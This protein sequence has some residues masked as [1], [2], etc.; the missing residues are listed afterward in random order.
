MTEQELAEHRS[1]LVRTLS[2]TLQSA[3]ADRLAQAFMAV[4]RHRYLP[5]LIGVEGDVRAG[6]DLAVTRMS[7]WQAASIYSDDALSLRPGDPCLRSTSSAPGI[8]WRMIDMLCLDPGARVLE[9]GCGSGYN[10]AVMGH[11]VGP[12]GRVTS[13]E[14]IADVAHDARV[15]LELEGVTNVDV[16]VGDGTQGREAGAPYDAVMV[17]AAARDIF[18]AWLWQLREGGRLVTVLETGLG[19]RL[20]GMARRGETLDGAFGLWVAFVPV[21]GR[22]ATYPRL[23]AAAHDVSARWERIRQVNS[24]TVP[25]ASSLTG[26]ATAGRGGLLSF[27]ELRLGLRAVC[28]SGSGLRADLL[29][30]SADGESFAAVQTS[31][32]AEAHSVEVCGSTSIEEELREHSSAFV[33]AGCPT[34]ENGRVVARRIGSAQRVGTDVLGEREYFEYGVC[35]KGN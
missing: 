4:P 15:C 28:S 33:K 25:L 7:P 13:V 22:E 14:V 35:G 31:W 1:R 2:A 20:L 23:S 21:V 18:P 16:L 24:R 29:M 9:I 17:T 34:V 10:A 6:L 3:R 30:A 27:L 8:M 5:R 32:Y 12:R 26:G 19:Q 11:L